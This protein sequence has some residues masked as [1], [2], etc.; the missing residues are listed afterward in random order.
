MRVVVQEHL[1]TAHDLWTL[2]H[3]PEYDSRRLELSEGELIEMSPA[4]GKHG[5]LASK[6]DR[7]IGIFVE[8]HQLGETT[9]AETG[10][11]L[12]KNPN[13]RDTVRAPDVGFISAARVPEGGLPEEGYIPVPPDLAVEVVSPN[14]DAE[15]LHLKIQQ[16]LKAGTRLVW[17][18]YPKSKS[19]AVHTPAGAHTIEIG[20]ALDGGNV[21]PGFSL[22]L[23]DV[24]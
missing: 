18:F 16:Y 12:Y 21:L 13:G 2:S 20:G 5:T 9:A 23:Q 1:Y 14:D 3:L 24:F 22:P 6:L 15:D 7:R 17:V 4:S 11:I 8:E 19:V 10:F